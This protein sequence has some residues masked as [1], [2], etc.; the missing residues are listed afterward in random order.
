MELVRDA[1][2]GVRVGT[3]E[4]HRN[5]ALLPLVARVD[6]HP[7]YLLLDESLDRNVARVTE[8]S[9][10][11]S[12]PALAFENSYAE[13]ILLVAGDELVGA[14]Q[15]RIVDLSILLGAGKKLVIPVSC[16][17]QGRWSYRSRDFTAANRTLF[18]KARA[19]KATQV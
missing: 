12:V 9:E 1:L 13:E 11:G 16:V 10:G 19:K 17:E 6:P 18:A 3:P 2:A 5:L 8:V 15:N 14:K 7:G 4:V